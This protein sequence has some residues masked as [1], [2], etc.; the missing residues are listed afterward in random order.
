M[1]GCPVGLIRLVNQSYWCREI[2]RTVLLKEEVNCY[3][4]LPIL[5]KW[6]MNC[7]QLPLLL[8]WWL[9]K[10][11]SIEWA[12]KQIDVYMISENVIAFWDI[13]SIHP[14]TP[15]VVLPQRVRFVPDR[16]H[17]HLCSFYIILSQF[18][19]LDFFMCR[20]TRLV[21][22]KRNVHQLLICYR[23]APAHIIIHFWISCV[24]SRQP[25]EV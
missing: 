9:Q 23:S 19:L 22:P 25:S 13:S 16:F 11:Y 2:R 14:E 18:W 10:N 15:I 3:Q 7:Y 20:L 1:N 6:E 4:L 8:N 17:S 5:L 12:F 24:Q 21:I